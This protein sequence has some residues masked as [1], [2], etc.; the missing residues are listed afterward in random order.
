MS[1]LLDPPGLTRLTA[2]RRYSYRRRPFP[3]LSGTLASGLSGTAFSGAGVAIGSKPTFVN[4]LDLN[5]SGGAVPQPVLT[6]HGANLALDGTFLMLKNTINGGATR[7]SWAAG[8]EHYGE[9]FALNVRT[10]STSAHYWVW[11]DDKP[12]T[13][14]PVSVTGLSQGAGYWIDLPFATTAYRRIKIYLYTLDVY[15]YAVDKTDGYGPTPLL[16]F[17]ILFWGDSWIQGASNIYLDHLPYKIGRALGAE[18]FLA[19]Q[20]GT[21]YVKTLSGG[22]AYGASDRLAAASVLTPDLIWVE[23]SINDA[24]LGGV[25]AAAT[26]FYTQLATLFPGVPVIVQGVQATGSGAG[27]AG[28]YNAINTDVLTAAAAAPNVVATINCRAESW[29]TGSGNAS[30]TTGDGNSD[31][32]FDS[33]YIHLTPAGNDFYARRMLAKYSELVSAR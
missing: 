6:G 4:L 17:S 27:F 23:G 14:A 13:T 19:G 16:P 30:S 1:G 5:Y 33:S 24:G 31:V 28:S 32:I 9:H 18:V 7:S 11:I 12:V 21:G 10:Q 20:G 15:G 2:D 25:Q 3:P 8:V 22:V 26:A 29:A